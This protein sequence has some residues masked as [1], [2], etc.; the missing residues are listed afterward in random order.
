MN[1]KSDVEVNLEELSSFYG[2]CE[3]PGVVRLIEFLAGPGS[4]LSSIGTSTYGL[5]EIL[6]REY[7]SEEERMHDACFKTRKLHIGG[8]GVTPLQHLT[9]VAKDFNTLPIEAQKK[10]D[11]ICNDFVQLVNGFESTEVTSLLIY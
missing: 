11:V 10:F 7:A 5:K 9:I 3:C 8:G 6:E 1:S 4:T 2:E